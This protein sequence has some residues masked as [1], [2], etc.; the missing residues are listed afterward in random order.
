MVTPIRE[1]VNITLFTTIKASL[2]NQLPQI[3]VS[4][5]M[6][7]N[8]DISRGILTFPI[9][10]STRESSI[11]SNVSSIPYYERMEI[12]RNNLFWSKQV[13]VKEIALSYAMNSKKDNVQTE[14]QIDNSPKI[15]LQHINNKTLAL[16]K[17]PVP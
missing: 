4:M 7:I 8:A 16:N 14:Q 13:E 10:N 12:Q 3:P 11:L 2:T 15:E 5:N 6:D 9:N 17:I 1:L